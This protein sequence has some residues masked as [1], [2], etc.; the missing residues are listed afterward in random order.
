[1][2]ETV[3]QQFLDDASRAQQTKPSI[4]I[5]TSSTSSCSSTASMHN[6]STAVAA[7]TA[8]HNDNITTETS[9]HIHPHLLKYKVHSPRTVHRIALHSIVLQN[10]AVQ[11]LQ[12]QVHALT[13][14]LCVCVAA[15]DAQGR[16]SRRRCSTKD[17]ARGICSAYIVMYN[18]SNMH[19][20]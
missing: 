10:S 8:V 11:R 13:M 20:L 3:I 5:T 18:L 14:C 1:M 2:S 6:Q 7:D 16:C 9:A 17:D 4:T 15:D 19:H 12:L